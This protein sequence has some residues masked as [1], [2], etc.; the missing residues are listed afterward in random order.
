MTKEQTKNKWKSNVTLFVPLEKVDSIN[1]NPKIEM[2]EGMT[3]Y[4]TWSCLF[5]D[6]MFDSLVE[7]T[8]RYATRDKGNHNFYLT[9]SDIYQFIGNI[10]F[11]G[12]HKVSKEGE[13]WSSQIDLHVPFIAN[14]MTRN[15][16]LQIKKYLRVADNRNLVEGSKVAKIKPLYNAFNVALKQFGILHGRLSIDELMVPYKGLHS[17]RQYVKSKPIKF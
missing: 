17:I 7:Q 1:F 6:A 11:S 9:R 12:Y 5:T 3:P 13:Y 15:R 8:Q 4:E 14:A 16:S 10:L 2:I